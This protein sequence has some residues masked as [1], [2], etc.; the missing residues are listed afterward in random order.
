MIRRIACLLLLTLALPACRDRIIQTENR[1]L[2]YPLVLRTRVDTTEITAG[3]DSM[4][5]LVELRNDPDE[6]DEG[7]VLVEMP[8]DCGLTY[9]VEDLDGNT[10]HPVSGEWLCFLLGSSLSGEVTILPGQPLKASFWWKGMAL[11][12]DGRTEIPVE[13]GNYRVYG[14]IGAAVDPHGNKVEVTIR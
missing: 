7:P 1:G 11:Q 9:A 12:Q 6:G 5:V 3:Q 10:V 4:L 2:P 13:P 8:D 14:G